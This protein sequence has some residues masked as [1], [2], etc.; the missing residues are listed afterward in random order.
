[1]REKTRRYQ[2][3]N[4]KILRSLQTIQN[5]AMRIE[6]GTVDRLTPTRDLL[7][8]T[9]RLSIHQMAALSIIRQTRTLLQKKAPVKIF[10][11]IQIYETRK[12][13][14]KYRTEIN[15]LNLKDESFLYK[16]VTIANRCPNSILDE[17]NPTKFK[18]NAKIWVRKEIRQKPY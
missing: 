16:A 14:T 5:G 18:K 11:K 17:K 1:M 4:K 8:Q 13:E 6:I 2:T 10:R 3:F 15:R 12:Q 9:Q 7:K